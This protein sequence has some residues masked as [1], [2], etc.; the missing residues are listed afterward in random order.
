MAAPNEDPNAKEIHDLIF[1]HPL[2]GL[3]QQISIMEMTCALGH[4][5]KVLS[6]PT[7]KP[8]QREECAELLA[9]TSLKIREIIFRENL[10]FEEREDAIDK[11]KNV[12]IGKS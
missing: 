12:L 4:F 5:Q 11:L 7:V 8:E 3:A 2:V 6:F 10:T 9:H 1:G